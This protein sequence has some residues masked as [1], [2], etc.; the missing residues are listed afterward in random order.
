MHF[1][2]SAP[3]RKWQNDL[4]LLDL[5]KRSFSFQIDT[6]EPLRQKRKSTRRNSRKS[7]K[8]TVFYQTRRNGRVTT[9]AMTLTTLRVTERA[10]PRKSTLIISSRPFSVGVAVECPTVPVSTSAE[11]GPGAGPTF[12][13]A[14]SHLVYITIT[15]C[16]PVRRLEAYFCKGRPKNHS[17]IE[18]TYAV[19]CSISCFGFC[20]FEIN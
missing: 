18:A 7:A 14:K 12:S 5:P 19:D 10:L 20:L 3:G 17:N 13:S 11:A 6:L 15:Y 16:S 1:S 9:M 2:F 4:L 8:P